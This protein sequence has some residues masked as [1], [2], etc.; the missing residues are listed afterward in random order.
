M[1]RAEVL[2]ALFY[3]SAFLSYR[4]AVLAPFAC[5]RAAS[6]ATPAADGGLAWR[7]RQRAVWFLV[8]CVLA[9]A[10]VLCKETALTALGLFVVEEALSLRR[11]QC[12]SWGGCKGAALRLGLIGSLCGVY[13]RLKAGLTGV[14]F[15]PRIASVDNSA[16]NAPTPIAVVL[17][18][19]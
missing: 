16:V 14:H 6:R 3:L 8:A 9:S 15:M 12:C 1:S 13:L 17:S 10:A 4:H 19:L 7:G 18:V 11:H 5:T 2:S